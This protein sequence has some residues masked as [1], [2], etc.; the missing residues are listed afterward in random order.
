MGPQATSACGC[1]IVS[2]ISGIAS[3]CGN[4][5]S[6]KSHIPVPFSSVYFFLKKPETLRRLLS[7]LGQNLVTCSLS[8]QK[9]VTTI[10]IEVHCVQSWRVS[11]EMHPTVY[12]CIHVW[13]W[14]HIH[15]YTFTYKGD[16]HVPCVIHCPKHLFD[17]LY[18]G[19]I[20]RVSR[21]LPHT[22]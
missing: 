21:L 22:G 16:V 5:H 1:K 7:V 4:I 10:Q 6:Q 18:K 15:T 17:S 19:E 20:L 13:V 2:A 11:A 3:T 14:S 8:N 9:M 12:L